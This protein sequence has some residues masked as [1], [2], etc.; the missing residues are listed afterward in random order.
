MSRRL[1]DRGSQLDAVRLVV[2]H[3]GWLLVMSHTHGYYTCEPSPFWM[4]NHR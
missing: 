3:S 4:A 2:C 1:S